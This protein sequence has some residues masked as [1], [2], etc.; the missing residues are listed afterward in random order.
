MQPRKVL[1]PLITLVLISLT[2]GLASAQGPRA[3]EPMGTAFTYQGRL[4]AGGS[5]AEGLYDFEFRLY[6]AA[7]GGTQVALPQT[8]H[9]VAVSRGLFAVTLDFGNVFTGQAM[10]LEVAVKG[11]GDA[12]FTTLSPRQ[13]LLPTPYALYSGLA[14]HASTAGELVTE[15]GGV[16]LQPGGVYTGG[17]NVIG[18]FTM[19]S[20]MP[21]ALGATI[22]GGGGQLKLPPDVGYWFNT[23]GNYATVGGGSDNHAEGENSTVGGGIHNSAGGSWATVGG[24]INNSATTAAAV[25]GGS[26]NSAAVN[27]SVG[28]GHSNTASGE[29]A[30]VPGGEG[31]LAQGAFSFAAGHNAQ[32]LH[33]G[34]FV[35]ADSGDSTFSSSAAD[36]FMVRAGG[37]IT[38]TI[39][40]GMLR[41]EPSHDTKGFLRTWG[42]NI[43]NF[44][45][46]TGQ[47][48]AGEGVVGATIS[49]GGAPWP[50]FYDGPLDARPNI[51]AEDFGTIGGG[52]SNRAEGYAASVGGGENNAAT[53]AY[54]TVAGGG[55]YIDTRGVLKKGNVAS[56]TGSAVGGGV[57]NEVGGAFGVIAGGT[58]NAVSA[59]HGAIGGGGGEWAAFGASTTGNRVTDA[60]GTVGG[61]HNNQ[62]GDNAGTSE[63]RP[64]ATVGG[65]HSNTASGETAT[66]GGGKDNVA[67]AKYT[68]VSGGIGNTA[69]YQYATVG[70]GWNNAATGDG[71]V[72]AGGVGNATSG[73]NG[74]IAGGNDN[75][76]GGQIASVGGGRN[77]N[78]SSYAST[79]GGGVSNEA[80]G[81]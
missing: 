46:G 57:G 59:D 15:V 42:A 5:P 37:G 33:D 28:G 29:A 9:D 68:T 40:G 10:W 11:P 65:G 44:V 80:T 74:T 66:I 52:L 16:R 36:Q 38:A 43:P 75:R 25:A 8:R 45:A 62:A 72:V 20:A 81:E 26:N 4:N 67:S 31:N 70:G 30:T 61:G 14:G 71:S 55:G 73:L 23:A 53:G 35:W 3:Q 24:G 60:Y 50:F 78:A 7:T 12:D 32:A 18:G 63:D 2:L 21:G 56:G 41:L 58:A 79:V 19:N 1:S 69:G 13:A 49:G 77:N 34:A 76:A 47:N 64:Y 51:V 22:G 39:A 27:A 6:D 54:S 17:P 48:F